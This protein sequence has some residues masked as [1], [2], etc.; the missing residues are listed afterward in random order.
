MDDDCG[1]IFVVTA[2]YSASLANDTPDSERHQRRARNRQHRHRSLRGMSPCHGRNRLRASEAMS[3]S[4]RHVVTPSIALKSGEQRDT[5]MD[6]EAISAPSESPLDIAV[7][8]TRHADLA[9]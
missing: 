3:L 7:T 4:A 1:T 2:Y 6:M 9:P 5:A 8:N